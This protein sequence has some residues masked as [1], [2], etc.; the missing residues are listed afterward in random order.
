MEATVKIRTTKPKIWVELKAIWG[1]GDVESTIKVSGRRWDEIQN[2]AE[3]VTSARYWYEGEQYSVEWHFAD[4]E[5]S[6]RGEDGA[7]VDLPV[8]EL[9]P[10]TTPPG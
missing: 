6:I 9:I 4:G 7:Q 3:Y 8:S 5:V 1:N 2:G 10:D